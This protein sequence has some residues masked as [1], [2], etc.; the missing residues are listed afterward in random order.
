MGQSLTLTKFKLDKVQKDK[1][2]RKYPKDFQVEVDACL[3]NYN[4]Y[5]NLRESTVTGS[6]DTF[7]KRDDAS[8]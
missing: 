4:I 3:S 7:L 1:N 8:P 2:H 6:A 5:D